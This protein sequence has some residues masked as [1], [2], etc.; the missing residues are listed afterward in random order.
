MHAGLA[1]M[2]QLTPEVY[3]RLNEQGTLL[4]HRLQEVT[5]RHKM[6]IHIT[7]IRPGFVDTAMAQGD[8]LFWVSSV[9]K[10]SKQIYNS[11]KAKR[12]VAYITRR[13][14]FISLVMKFVP[15]CIYNKA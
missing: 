11:I 1:T 5:C 3:D 14:W 8:H 13:W 15:D 9:E 7:D 12:K 2:R 6:P 10:A 4:R